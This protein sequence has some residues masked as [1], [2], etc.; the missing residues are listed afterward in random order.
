MT[1][2]RLFFLFIIKERNPLFSNIGAETCQNSSDLRASGGALWAQGIH[3]RAG[4]EAVNYCLCAVYYHAVAVA[5]CIIGIAIGAVICR[6]D[7][8]RC[9]SPRPIANSALPYWELTGAAVVSVMTKLLLPI[10]K[11]FLV[12][13]RGWVALLL[14]W[15][16]GCKER[17]II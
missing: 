1:H 9:F 14:A 10:T 7:G 4:D 11:V 6:T 15:I 12:K 2:R 8:F 5:V 17:T 3:I 16:L 13:S